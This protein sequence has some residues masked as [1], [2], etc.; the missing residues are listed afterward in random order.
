MKCVLQQ[1]LK[2]K[3]K[4]HNCVIFLKEIIEFKI[5]YGTIYLSL[6]LWD[7]IPIIY[8]DTFFNKFKFF[9]YIFRWQLK[10][11]EEEKS[12]NFHSNSFLSWFFFLVWWCLRSFACCLFSSQLNS[13]SCKSRIP[14]G[15]ATTTSVTKSKYLS[16]NISVP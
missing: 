12:T 1:T 8:S 5:M 6:K 9:S 7:L 16:I 3:F 4:A 11:L 14:C 2:R 10:Y 13:I 15:V